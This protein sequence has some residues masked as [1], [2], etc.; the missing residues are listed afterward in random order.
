MNNDSVFYLFY[1][2]IIQVY[3]ILN[4]AAA[5]AVMLGLS[6][7]NTVAERLAISKQVC[8]IGGT[9]LFIFALCGKV[10]LADI[11]HISSEAFQVGGG[12]YLFTI[13][14]GMALSKNSDNHEENSMVTEKS[15]FNF[16]TTPLATPL[17][18]GPENITAILVKRDELPGSTFCIV[19]FYGALIVRTILVDCTFLL[20]C[21]FSK[22]LTPEIR[23]VFEKLVG[24]LLMCITIG[25]IL[26]GITKF[27][28]GN[29]LD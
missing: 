8:I 22:C 18:T 20:A 11:F 5:I 19:A 26:K 13:G 1:T 6:T 14:L 27:L 23:K 4:P 15:A 12:L 25:S 24:I 17:L 28:Q 3:I 7:R 2:T 29:I 16:V 9:L 21:K 10:I